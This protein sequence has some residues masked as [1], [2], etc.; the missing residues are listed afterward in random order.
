MYSVAGL[1]KYIKGS[2][3][4]DMN[5]QSILVKGEVSNF[6]NHRS[7]HWYFSLK[8]NKAKIQLRHVFFLC[9]QM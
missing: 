7:G 9:M 4:H 3:D 8:D 2:L 6:T 1:V 5:L